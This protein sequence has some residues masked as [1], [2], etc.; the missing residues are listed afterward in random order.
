MMHH[1][2]RILLLR[3]LGTNSKVLKNLLWF[4]YNKDYYNIGRANSIS[5]A[6]SLR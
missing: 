1:M 6:V 3:N 2:E 5:C 4:L